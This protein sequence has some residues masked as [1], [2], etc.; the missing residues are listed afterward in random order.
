MY[1]GCFR[2]VLWV[3]VVVDSVCFWL[4]VFVGEW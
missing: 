3:V 4:L 1:V 2:S